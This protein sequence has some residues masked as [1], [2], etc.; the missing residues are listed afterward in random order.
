MYLIC[1][2]VLTRSVYAGKG[3]ATSNACNVKCDVVQELT[4]FRQLLN[5]ESILRMNT[6]N[7]IKD[8]KKMITRTRSSITAVQHEN[9]ATKQKLTMLESSVS[10]EMTNTRAALTTLERTV[11]SMNQTYQGK[12]AVNSA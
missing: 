1:L 2:S 8:L 4:L 6:N 10:T 7:E 11:T 9:K 5:Q 12:Y 3:S